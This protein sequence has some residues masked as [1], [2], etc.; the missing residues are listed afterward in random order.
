MIEY[1]NQFKMSFSIGE[2][3][4]FIR[5]EDMLLLKLVEQA[6]NVMP[7][8]ELHFKT[9][10]PRLFKYLNETNPLRFQMG[11]TEIKVDTEYKIYHKHIEYDSLGNYT[12]QI[13]ALLNNGNYLLAPKRRTIGNCTSD[14]ASLSGLEILRGVAAENFTLIESN[15]DK[16]EDFMLRIQPAISNKAFIDEIWQTLYTPDTFVLCGITSGG[17]FKIMDM[18]KLVGDKPKW[19]FTYKPENPKREIQIKDPKIDDN[20]GVNNYLFGYIRQQEFWN[21]DT[22]DHYVSTTGNETLMSMS[23][24]FNRDDIWLFNTQM[25][26]NENMYNE[27]WEC[28]NTNLSNWALFSSINLQ[29]QFDPQWY[30]LEV[31]DLVMVSVKD[32][33]E[34]PEEAFSGLAMVSTVARVFKDRKIST[35]VSLNREGFN[36]IR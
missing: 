16:S 11:V 33:Q 27:Y 3:Q 8:M 10:Q 23:K 7:A 28:R 12:V 22:A 24:N 20:S 9:C 29:I 34:Q 36:I 14:G 30:D 6:G 1:A 25:A 21:E 35:V 19:N 26:V 2:F 31:L 18:R 15:A 13:F 5:E 32:P 17:K 4:D